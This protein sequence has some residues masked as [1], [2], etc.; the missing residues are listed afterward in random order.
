MA[1]RGVPSEVKA[2]GAHFKR[3][4]EGGEGGGGNDSKGAVS[5]RA[6]SARRAVSQYGISLT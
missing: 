6:A 4:R 2:Y 1:V 3:N 5:K